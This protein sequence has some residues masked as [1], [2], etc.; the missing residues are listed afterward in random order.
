MTS[1]NVSR[2]DLLVGAGGAGLGAAIGW[3]GTA[4]ASKPERYNVGIESPAAEAATRSAAASIHREFDWGGGKKT[5]SGSF[6]EA[7][8]EGLRHRPG[9]RYV[10]V[11]GEMHALAQTMPWGIDRVDAD[12]AHANDETGGGA[13]IAIIDTGIDDDHPDLQENIGEGVAFVSCRGGGCNEDWS[14]DNDHGTH[15]AGIAAAVDNDE[16][17]VGVAP[18]ATLHAVKVLDKRGSGS[19]SD[20]AAGIEWTADQGYDVA[21][22]S[23]GASSGSQTVEDA[24]EYAYGE[25]VLLVAAAG[26]DGACT[27]CVGYPAAYPEVIAV[28]STDE[29]DSLSSFSSTGPEVELAAPG[30]SIYSTVVGGYDT[31]SGTSMACPHVSGAGG[32][33]MANGA[34]NEEARQQLADTAEDLGLG[35]NEQGNGLLDVA[36]ALGIEDDGGDD[37]GGGDEN[38]APSCS[39]ANPNDGDTVSDDV[40]IQVDAS[41]EEDDDTS[42]DVEVAIDDGTWNTAEYDSDSGSYE[43]G[44]DTTAEDDGDHTID[45]RA[46]DSDGATTDADTISVTVDNGDDGGDDG[47]DNAPVIDQFDVSARTSGPWS[48][49]DVEWAVSDEDG[50][51]ADVTSELLDSSG[52]V[53]DSESSSVSGSSDSGEHNLRTRSDPVEVS[54]TVTDAAGNESSDTKTL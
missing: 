6:P 33:V 35:D 27:D 42:L 48:R 22:L 52:G 21:S 54:L 36:A 43:Y 49:A 40:T 15:C 26:N 51:L 53:L 19:F 24:C 23:L 18:E 41:D 12:V 44:W 10:E 16:G 11:D 20:V 38:T 14:D 46:T 32:Q 13:D 4:S 8:L 5:I 50:D 45:A 29:D 17:V 31:F 9:I 39:I 3:P 47:G 1:R 25:G 37:G 34:S 28:S 30:G 2:R 7:A